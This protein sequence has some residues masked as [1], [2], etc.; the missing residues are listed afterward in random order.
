MSER[1]E[2]GK[3]PYLCSNTFSIADLTFA[4]LSAPLV[5]VTKEDGYGAWIPALGDGSSEGL[6]RYLYSLRSSRA[7]QH[8]LDMYKMH[9]LAP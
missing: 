6:R 7:G 4:A 2:K 9:R 1:L 3:H 5:G 8:V